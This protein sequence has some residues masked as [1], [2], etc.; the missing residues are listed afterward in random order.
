[1]TNKI[2]ITSGCSF[3]ECINDGPTI[4]WPRHLSNLL[5]N[6]EHKSYAMGSQG[7]GLISRSIIYAVTEAL[8]TYKPEDILVGVMWSGFTR[9][10][11]R[12]SGEEFLSFA[13]NDNVDGWITN[14]T[15]FMKEYPEVPNNWLIM[16]W[17]WKVKEAQT[18]YNNFFDLIGATIY[19]IEHI[20]RTQWFLKINQIKYFFTDFACENLG[21]DE[22]M[23]NVEIKY[24]HDQ[25]D[26]EQYLPVKSEYDWIYINSKF[27]DRWTQLGKNPKEHP[28]TEHHKEFT[29]QVIFPWLKEKYSTQL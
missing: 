13:P 28:H 2:L 29:E 23:S 3:S 4:T 10:D 11:Y 7:N 16:N 20:L 6:Y 17:G 24:L 9:H 8:K 19:S 27:S 15:K 18:Y 21:Y 5:P 22:Y 26:R 14:P 12:I 25:I 1:M